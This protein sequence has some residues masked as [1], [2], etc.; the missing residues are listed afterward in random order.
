MVATQLQSE[1]QNL[2]AIEALLYDA[3]VKHSFISYVFSNTLLVYKLRYISNIFC[4][5][6]S[7]IDKDRGK[8][9][10]HYYINVVFIL[11]FVMGALNAQ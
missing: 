8:T 1:L 9:I 6:L 3:V 7:T 2:G 4:A 11:L 10:V 5:L